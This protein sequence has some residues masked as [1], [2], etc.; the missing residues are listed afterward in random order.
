MTG[1]GGFVAAAPVATLCAMILR[2][3]IE[4]G[5]SIE[6]ITHAGHSIAF[7]HFVTL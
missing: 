7:L 1:G 2:I 3:T 4:V 6:C 5:H